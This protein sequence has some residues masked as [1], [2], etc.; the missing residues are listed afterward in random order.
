MNHNAQIG[1]RVSQDPSMPV[2]APC[3]SVGSV[4]MGLAAIGGEIDQLAKSIDR[5]R[6]KLS[7]VLKQTPSGDGSGADYAEESVCEV[8]SQLRDK[9]REITALYNQVESIFERLD[10]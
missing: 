2:D 3:V 8:G 10:I 7:P 9:G 1:R 5:L 4:Q 6:A